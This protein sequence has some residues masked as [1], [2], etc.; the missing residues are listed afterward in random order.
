M[1]SLSIFPLHLAEE[2]L[3]LEEAENDGIGRL[4]EQSQQRNETDHR[5]SAKGDGFRAPAF[6]VSISITSIQISS[7][8]ATGAVSRDDAAAMPAQSPASAGSNTPGRSTELTAARYAA[9]IMN[10]HI[11]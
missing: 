4:D 5:R 10:R 2:K 7:T 3:V 6:R 8:G 1:K 11:P 9:T